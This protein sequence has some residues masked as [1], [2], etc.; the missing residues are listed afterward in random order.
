MALFGPPDVTKLSA[1]RDIKGLIRALNYQKDGGV[2]R[3]ATEA[4]GRMGADAVE[5]LVASLED[6]A[7][8]GVHASAA[9]ALGEI[10]DARAVEPLI[11]AL[12]EEN[13]K[14]AAADAL[15]QIGDP[16]AVEPLIAAL[17]DLSGSTRG[18][19]AQALGL[20]DDPRAVEPLIAA[21]K[22]QNGGER[23]IV[24]ALGH[25]GDPRAVEPLIAALYY[26]SVVVRSRAADA[27]GKIGDSGAV[28]P[29]VATLT[30][31]D[32]ALR[33]ERETSAVFKAI[34]SIDPSRTAALNTML[35]DQSG[36]VRTH[37]AAALGS[38]GDA[39]AVE[40]LVT[41]LKDPQH[42]L[43]QVAADAL[44]AIGDARAIEPLQAALSDADEAVREAAARAVQSFSV[45]SPLAGGAL[46][47]NGADPSISGAAA[48]ARAESGKLGAPPPPA[49]E[50]QPVAT[51][52][53]PAGVTSE[54]IPAAAVVCDTFMSFD[55]DE[56]LNDYATQIVRSKWPGL[57]LAGGTKI[58]GA[59]G[60]SGDD[61]EAT[62]IL[63]EMLSRAAA[64]VGL[65]RADYE[66]TYFTARSEVPATK[67]WCML[68]LKR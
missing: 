59:M 7:Q 17:K 8:A 13:A 15:G 38:I 4:L 52:A 60:F 48:Q 21:L 25:L 26:D 47:E 35:D 14:V 16:R 41:A 28:E 10:G 40:P 18:N 43:R 2:R 22:E 37:A 45:L 11:A 23:L 63:Q 31:K 50:T 34:G 32:L 1:K 29:L 24:E 30:D 58:E 3:A 42:L 65:E 39:R 5:P 6:G 64:A 9:Q 36:F 66:V 56:A 62:M 12:K 54:M 20:I 27:L 46:G 67:V 61:D 19:I 44:G 68:A 55:S 53:P 57:Q 33:D 49:A 51:V